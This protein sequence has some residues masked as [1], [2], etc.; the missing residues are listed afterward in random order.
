MN[1]HHG[2]ITLHLPQFHVRTRV[3][4]IAHRFIRFFINSCEDCIN[5]CLKR[6]Q[7]SP[8]RL[9]NVS[10]SFNLVIHFICQFSQGLS[11]FFCHLTKRH[12]IMQPIYTYNVSLSTQN[13]LS[14]Q[15]Y[16]YCISLFLCLYLAHHWLIESEIWSNRAY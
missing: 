13:T 15:T 10:T 1:Y 4:E 8:A 2:R 9:F 14:C 5:I 3:K 16:L 6:I 11:Q 12:D 7:I